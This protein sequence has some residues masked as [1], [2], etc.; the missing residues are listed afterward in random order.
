[1]VVLILT[2]FFLGVGG[3]FWLLRMLRDQERERQNRGASVL[4]SLDRLSVQNGTFYRELREAIG[5]ESRQ[6]EREVEHHK[7]SLLTL[8]A[9]LLTTQTALQEL[10]G[11]TQSSVVAQGFNTYAKQR[12]ERHRRHVLEEPAGED[13]LPSDGWLRN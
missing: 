6:R 10:V 2:C 11:K 3:Y 13:S 8:N 9:T 5:A 4:A 7:N 1:M 12:E